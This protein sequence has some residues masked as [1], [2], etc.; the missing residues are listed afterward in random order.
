MPEARE[1]ISVLFVCMG[2]I[3]RSPTAEG[4]FRKVV[5]DAGLAESVLIESAGTHA[6]HTNEPADRRAMAAAKRRGFSLDGIRARSVNDEDFQ[7]FD[8][9]LAMDRD[10]LRALQDRSSVADRHKLQLFLS[11]ANAAET[12]VPDPYYGDSAGFERVL[13]LVENASR[14]L[15][16]EITR[17]LKGRRR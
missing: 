8:L 1:K 17:Q 4:V 14:G 6:Y 3:C 13:D 11:Y 7:R 15:L 9:L 2:N 5:N 16:R 12:E 10:N